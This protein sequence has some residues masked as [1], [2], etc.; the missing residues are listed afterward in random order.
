[1]QVAN[2]SSRSCRETQS[3]WRHR[4]IELLFLLRESSNWNEGPGDAGR[5]FERMGKTS[6][7]NSDYEGE[8]AHAV[9]MPW[10]H[11]GKQLE[12]L[13]SAPLLPPITPGP[14]WIGACKSRA[15]ARSSPPHLV[16]PPCSHARITRVEQL[17]LPQL[18]T[19]CAISRLATN[20]RELHVICTDRACLLG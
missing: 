16:R 11:F 5:I 17:R 2:S 9:K 20:P 19:I 8:H 4:G 1:M 6:L 12:D 7:G 3:T 14:A 18:S 15:V 13:V 10:Y